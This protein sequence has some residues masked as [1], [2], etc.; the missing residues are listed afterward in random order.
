MKAVHY[1]KRGGA[2]LSLYRAL[3]IL[4]EE[5]DMVAREDREESVAELRRFF[6]W[7]ALTDAGHGLTAEPSAAFRAREEAGVTS[8]LEGNTVV[9]RVSRKPAPE[10]KS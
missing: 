1:E 4:L 10:V 5:R 6:D 3:S 7:L 9:I 2:S 8:K